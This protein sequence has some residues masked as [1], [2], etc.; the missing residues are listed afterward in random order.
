MI[1]LKRLYLVAGFDGHDVERQSSELQRKYEAG[2]VRI[3]AR[4][5]P[6]KLEKRVSYLRAL[7]RS[8]ND[9][10]FGSKTATRAG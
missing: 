8:A 3:L 7:V 5:Y 9:L 2:T 6:A 10:I 1:P 4:T